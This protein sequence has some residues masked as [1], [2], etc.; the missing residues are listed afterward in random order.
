MQGNQRVATCS[1][2]HCCMLQLGEITCKGNLMMAM[3]AMLTE[4][5]LPRHV[6]AISAHP[7]T[8]SFLGGHNKWAAL[9]TL[10]GFQGH[11]KHKILQWTQ[12]P[13]T[14]EET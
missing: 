2:Q 14:V 7:T 8:L 10:S 13:A 5:K 4:A 3:M 1:R 12:L 11:D 9:G 6:K